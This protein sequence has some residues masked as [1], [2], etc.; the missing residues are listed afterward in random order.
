MSNQL[1]NLVFEAKVD[2]EGEYV[3][4]SEWHK[5]AAEAL[6]EHEAA[7]PDEGQAARDNALL[8]RGIQ[9]GKERERQVWE[10]QLRMGSLR[11]ALAHEAAKPD[12]VYYEFRPVS[13]ADEW[14][15]V[16]PRD[17]V[18]GVGEALADI[19]A[20]RYEGKPCYEIRALYA[21][22]VAVA[23][24]WQ[25]IETAPKDGSAILVNAGG[26]C[27]AV[28]WS[29]EFDWWAVDDNK[30]GPFRLRGQAPTHWMPLPPAPKE[31]A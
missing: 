29:D 2:D 25:P 13:G 6:A 27:Y 4:G 12:P 11:A 8:E 16:E 21:A 17:R 19:R 5:R 9:V 1:A 22:P 31:Q 26:F 10:H 30:L 20:Y 23:S 28:E 18:Y 24:Q 14:R 3:L 15:R 7:K